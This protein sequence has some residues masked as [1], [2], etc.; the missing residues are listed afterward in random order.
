MGLTQS[1]AEP[2]VA[3]GKRSLRHILHAAG[4]RDAS[5]TDQNV[6]GAVDHRLESGAAQSVDGER[7][8]I[9]GNAGGEEHVAGEEGAIRLGSL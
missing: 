6:L 4:Q 8:P 9:D 5:G 3:H 1:G 7:R 2:N